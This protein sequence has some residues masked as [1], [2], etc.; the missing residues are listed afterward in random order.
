MFLIYRDIA[1][2]FVDFI[3][4]NIELFGKSVYSIIILHAIKLEPCDIIGRVV[5]V[6]KTVLLE[7]ERPIWSEKVITNV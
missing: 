1:N 3:S 2:V 6:D 4:N 7:Y 5:A